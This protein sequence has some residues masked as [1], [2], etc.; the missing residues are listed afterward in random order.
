MIVEEQHSL[1]SSASINTA[2]IFAVSFYSLHC[3]L[4]VVRI[5]V[6]CVSQLCL[7]TSSFA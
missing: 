3:Y 4:S 2:V 1:C 5:S 7:N 6:P